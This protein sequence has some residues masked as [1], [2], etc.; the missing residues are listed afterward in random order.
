[1]THWTAAQVHTFEA[2]LGL[3][4]TERVVLVGAGALA[5]HLDLA[6]R[7]TADLDLTVALELDDYLRSLQQ[8]HG[9][10]MDPRRE[11]R[12][13]SPWGVKVDLLPAGPGLLATGKLVWPA[14]GGEMRLTGLDLAFEQFVTEPLPQATL[15]VASLPALVVLKM[16]SWLD[17]PAERDR[18]LADLGHVLDNAVPPDDERRFSTHVID[19]AIEYELVC[20][21][22]IGTQVGCIARGSHRAVIDEFLERLAREE[23]WPHARMRALGPWAWRHDETALTRRLHA[24]RAGV[25]FGG[26]G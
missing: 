5:R 18:D 4:G 10:N 8:L 20:A 1:M 7:V 24:F 16:T 3:W 25:D 9:W 14:G 6:W 23:D 22:L 15:R 26:S 11:H 19:L 21:Y 12:V 13:T 17:R 2:L